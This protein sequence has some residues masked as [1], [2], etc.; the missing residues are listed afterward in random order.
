MILHCREAPACLSRPD[1]VAV[2]LHQIFI[3]Y[4]SPLKLGS[5]KEKGWQN[6]AKIGGKEK[7]KGILSHFCKK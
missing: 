2:M 5:K 6:V 4:S 3:K 7:E 1:G